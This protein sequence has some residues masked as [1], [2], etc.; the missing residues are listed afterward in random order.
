MSNF[1]F[2]IPG[3]EP[4]LGPQYPQNA[5]RTNIFGERAANRDGRS[6]LSAED[7]IVLAKIEVSIMRL[8][9]IRA[10]IVSLI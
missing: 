3:L 5:M 9:T 4:T 6:G 10:G 1:A 8:E 7:A 2:N